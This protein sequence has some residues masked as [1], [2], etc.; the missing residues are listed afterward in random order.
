MGYDESL[1]D[2]DPRKLIVKL[3]GYAGFPQL[4]LMDPDRNVIE[5]NGPP[6]PA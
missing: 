2:D 3:T 1:P 4:Y 6:W 5:L